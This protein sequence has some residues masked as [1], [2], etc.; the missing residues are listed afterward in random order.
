MS[1]LVKFIAENVSWLYLILAVVGLWLLRVM[2]IAATERK[3]SIFALERENATTRLNRAIIN[4]FFL[5][6]LAGGL[7]YVSTSLV[8]QL[9]LPEETPTPTL[10]VELP[11]TPTPPPLLPTPI[12]QPAESPTP[13]DAANNP[14]AP[15]NCPNPG[16]HI[17]QPGNGAVVSGVIQIVGAANIDNMD[18]YK[19]EF[20]APGGDWNFIQNY[21]APVPDGLLATWNTDT[22]PPGEYRFR[23][24]VVDKTGNY[25]E[26][27]EI[28]LSVQR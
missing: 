24:V 6:V 27:C 19:I 8:K 4:L 12:P 23:L 16:A 2:S 11:P 26:P 22:V 17:T 10:V 9:P 13:A 25:P 7:Y 15:P 20:Q 28:K 18:Y 3:R 14:G 1:I 5:F 21:T